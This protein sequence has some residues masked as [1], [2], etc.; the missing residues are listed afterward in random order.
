MVR[1]GRCMGERSLLV[2]TETGD[3]RQNIVRHRSRC[4]TRRVRGRRR[5]DR[6]PAHGFLDRSA[7]GAVRE[8]GPHRIAKLDRREVTRVG[9]AEP[10]RVAGRRFPR[11]Y[12]PAGA[13]DRRDLAACG[14]ER[15]GR[16]HGRRPRP[17][18]RIRTLCVERDRR[19]K[20]RRA[21]QNAEADRPPRRL[22]RSDV[23]AARDRRTA[24]PTLLACP[25][26][27]GAPGVLWRGKR[28]VM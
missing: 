8:V 27:A 3:V 23:R 5:E 20:Q 11:G 24:H 7:H 2:M 15:R 28:G 12:G 17:P 13:V 22:R 16:R 18:R 6:A 10:E 4:P 1:I 25:R 21:G 14:D 9:N 19:S 26:G